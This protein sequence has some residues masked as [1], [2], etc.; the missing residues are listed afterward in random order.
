VSLPVDRLEAQL[1]C[2]EL[3]EFVG[4]AMARE[5]E[6]GNE[7]ATFSQLSNALDRSSMPAALRGRVGTSVDAQQVLRRKAMAKIAAAGSPMPVVREC[8]RRFG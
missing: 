5:D 4:K 7:L 1:G 2:D 3:A 8:I 6:Y